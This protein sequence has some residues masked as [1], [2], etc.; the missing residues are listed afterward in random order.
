[1]LY[2][3]LVLIIII[4]TTRLLLLKGQMKAISKQL[5]AR[6]KEGSQKYID[7]ALFDKDLTELAVQINTN[8]EHENQLRIDALRADK[9]LKNSVANISH[10]L[11]TP[12]TSIIGYLQLLERSNLDDDGKRNVEIAQ[13]KAKMMHKLIDEFFELS[14]LESNDDLPD[15]KRINLTNFVTECILDNLTEFERKNIVPNFE[16]DSAPIFVLADQNMLKRVMQ[17]LLMNCINYS[18]GD[19]TI[20]VSAADKAILATKNPVANPEEIDVDMLFNRFY[21]G[22][23]SRNN[24]GT[25]LGLSI[26]KLLVQKT[27]GSVKASLNDDIL[28]IQVFLNRYA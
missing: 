11:R 20:S 12:L 24:A 18:N 5:L 14:M 6:L 2:S 8:L 4:L 7:I 3:I 10:D 13:K 25:G 28:E 17:N 27:N 26:V 19:V 16:H 23:K 9:E 1:M 21:T 15:L 22:D